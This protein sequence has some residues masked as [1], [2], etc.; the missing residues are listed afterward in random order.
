MSRESTVREWRTRVPRY[1]LLGGRC[2]DCGR[3]FYPPA[4][5]CPYCG[6]RNVAETE[7]PR[8]GRLEAYTVLYSV[9]SGARDRS[10]VVIGLVDLGVAKVVS[11]IVDVSDPESLERGVQVEAVFRRIYED[12]DE[13]V[14]VYGVKF[15]PKA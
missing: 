11:E 13:G 8:V 10:P 9:E 5:A 3:S 1:R 2:S 7:L 6:S 14:I 12:G 15:R 4:K